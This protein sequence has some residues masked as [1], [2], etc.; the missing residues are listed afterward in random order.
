MGHVSRG[1]LL[2]LFS[3][4]TT[5][6]LDH[7]EI[8]NHVAGCSRCWPL[9]GSALEQLEAQGARLATSEPVRNLIGLLRDQRERSLAYLGAR[10]R[11]AKLKRL[12]PAK[13]LELF[14]TTAVYRTITVVTLLLR[15]TGDLAKSGRDEAEDYGRSTLTLIELLSP[16]VCHDLLKNDLRGQVWI[17][18]AN[19]RRIN[20]AWKEANQALKLAEGLLRSGT[21][22]PLLAA[23]L[24]SI[25]SSLASDTGQTAIAVREAIMAQQ[26]YREMEDRTGLATTLLKEANALVELDPSRAFSLA[27][28]GLSVTDEVEVRLRMQF[29]ST[30]LECLVE[31]GRAAEA[32]KIL[33]E[34]RP[35]YEQFK[36]EAKV[37][38]RVH[39]VEARLLE[40]LGRFQ[41]AELLY[42]D[43]METALEEG[44]ARDS[45][46][47]RLMLFN[48]YFLRGR[49]DE[50]AA[51]CT[52]GVWAL[53]EAG[54]HQ[55]MRAVWNELKMFTETRRVDSEIIK[56]V[57]LYHVEHWNTP[58]KQPPLGRP[59]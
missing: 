52:E 21:G 56:A 23:R 3:R 16:E 19:G 34:C 12:S 4:N 51:V 38:V 11:L 5:C 25:R 27:E 10:G 40:A 46:I 6:G 59:K 37:Q 13:R 39:A 58:A 53:H 47:A 1:Q 15:E 8:V 50:A 14:K 42:R 49:L 18:L 31:L 2:A 29:K 7:G 28:E 32:L 30:A 33:D 26:I 9:A 44:F 43:V 41:E 36:N 35:L 17:E 22:S 45:F 54:A 48:F 55:Q 20:A 24:H 57:R